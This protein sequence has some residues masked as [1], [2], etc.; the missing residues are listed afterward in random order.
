MSI[1]RRWMQKFLRLG[2]NESGQPDTG[3][4]EQSSLYPGSSR[5]VY[6]SLCRTRRSQYGNC[7]IRWTSLW[8][9][10]SNE[11]GQLGQGREVSLLTQPTK[12]QTLIQISAGEKFS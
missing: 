6:R 11:A 7:R 1:N 10:D 3:D 9:W 4:R 5:E 8:S 2:C 12:V